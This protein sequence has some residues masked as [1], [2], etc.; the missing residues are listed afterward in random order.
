MANCEEDSC[1]N[2]QSVICLHCMR[3][4]CIDHLDIHRQ[5]LS[6]KIEEFK[7]EF[8]HIHTVLVNASIT[9]A[10]ER[11]N[12]ENKW[13]NWRLEKIAD[14]ER[15]YNQMIDSIRN[16]QKLL[17]ELELGLKQRLKDEIQQPLEEMLLRKSVNL[18]LLDTIQLTIQTIKKESESLSWNSEHMN[19]VGENKMNQQQA[20]T[21]E[22]SNETI[23]TP[24]KVKAWKPRNSL[25]SLFLDVSPSSVTNINEYIQTSMKDENAMEQ[26][27]LIT[28]VYSYLLTWHQSKSYE[29]QAT[30]LILNKHILTIKQYIT[31]KECERKVLIAMQ[32]F[33][34]Q[35]KYNDSSNLELMTMLLHLFLQHQCIST[36]EMIDWYEKETFAD[37][38]L[39]KK[40]E[41]K[42]AEPFLNQYGY[43]IE[44]T[45]SEELTCTSSVPSINP[46]EKISQPTSKTCEHVSI[47]KPFKSLVKFFKDIS[48]INDFVIHAYIEHQYTKN[49]TH[50]VI[51]IVRSYL[52]A[53]IDVSSKLETNFLLHKISVIRYY[54]S[55]RNFQ[56]QLLFA[57]EVFLSES[58]KNEKWSINVTS[59][60]FQFFFSQNCLDRKTILKWYDN[61]HIYNE[62]YYQETKAFARS[63]IEGLNGS[64]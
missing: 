36:A 17:E 1:S 7:D 63:F 45:A 46:Q 41:K 34:Y 40:I 61:G 42:W 5:S 33:D 14:I 28:L 29:D 64:I 24:T 15:E 26:Y 23:T 47:H 9:V 43:R 11:T 6:N 48:H 22:K 27:G 16:R 53:W 50:R 62:I 55:D 12:N 60:L 13:N 37:Q 3:R 57:I 25:F 32:F 2:F 54:N 51:M 31:G 20:L 21:E 18:P 44:S 30:E 49:I 19:T 39:E 59:I 10:E 4:I 35:L 8:N 56:M 58:K 38:I 52:K